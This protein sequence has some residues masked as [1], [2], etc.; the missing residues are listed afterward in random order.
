MRGYPNLFLFSLVFLLNLPRKKKNKKKKTPH[1][2]KKEI[3][4]LNS[5]VDTRIYTRYRL[6]ILPTSKNA[7]RIMQFTCKI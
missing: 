7:N 4:V 5:L 1:P 2:A 3:H 6:H